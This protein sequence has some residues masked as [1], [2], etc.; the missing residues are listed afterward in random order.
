M[1]R[2]ATGAAF[3]RGQQEIQAL[4]TLA[5]EDPFSDDLPISPSFPLRYWD[6]LL[7]QAYLRHEPFS[8]E[9]VPPYGRAWLAAEFGKQ[10][11]RSPELRELI[12]HAGEEGH[13]LIGA[14]YR[15]M[16]VT[17]RPTPPRNVPGSGGVSHDR[18][19]RAR[20]AAALSGGAPVSRRRPRKLA[21]MPDAVW[22]AV[23]AIP[24]ERLRGGRPQEEPAAITV[25]GRLL[26]DHIYR[27]AAARNDRR[28][29]RWEQVATLLLD[30]CGDPEYRGTTA[31]NLRRR[32]LHSRRAGHALTSD[33]LK[34]VRELV[35]STEHALSR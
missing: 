2:G 10:L 32:V 11:R 17:A 35:D 24:R 16:E 8:W 14:L 21:W 30:F 5:S 31:Q 25:Y 4:E 27:L 23:S 28:C 20:R 13:F 29:R 3:R 12:A 15:Y 1:A 33:Y 9:R 7:R 26:T 19:Y 18:R 34:A 22:A 6:E